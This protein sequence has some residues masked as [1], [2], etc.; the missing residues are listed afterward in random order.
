[1]N[2]VEAAKVLGI[3]RGT[4]MDEA[5]L[6]QAYRVKAKETHP[7]AG[8]TDEAFHAVL[9]ARSVLLNALKRPQGYTP[10][11]SQ[12]KCPK[13]KGTG[14]TESRRAWHTMRVRCAECKGAGAVKT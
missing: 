11:P 8:G 10:P 9:Q 3:P 12:A 7:D 5:T 4:T 2:I 1:M 14:T 13:C 6:D